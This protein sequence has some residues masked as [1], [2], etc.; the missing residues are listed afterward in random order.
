MNKGRQEDILLHQS[1]QTAFK[2]APTRGEQQKNLY[3]KLKVRE[4]TS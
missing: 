1:L 2:E 4:I 3:V